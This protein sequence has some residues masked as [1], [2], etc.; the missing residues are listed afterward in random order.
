[1]EIWSSSIPGFR[2]FAVL[3]IRSSGVQETWN[4]IDGKFWRFGVLG[5]GDLEFWSW[6]GGDLEIQSSRV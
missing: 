3:Q 1:M 5:S 2:R 4:A 6:G